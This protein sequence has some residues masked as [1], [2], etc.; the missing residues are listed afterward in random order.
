MAQKRVAKPYIVFG[1]GHPNVKYLGWASSIF[2][3]LSI[4]L[5]KQAVVSLF[6]TPTQ[7]PT[8]KSVLTFPLFIQ[9]LGLVYVMFYVV[10][11]F[12]YRYCFFQ[13]RGNVARDQVLAMAALCGAKFTH[14]G[15]SCSYTD[16]VPLRRVLEK[17]E[18]LGNT[19]FCA[20]INAMIKQQQQQDSTTTT[21][22]T[23]VFAVNNDFAHLMGR[24]MRQLLSHFG[25]LNTLDHVLVLH[26]E[27][28]LTS[29]AFEIKDRG[30]CM[31]HLGVKDLIQRVVIPR[32]IA[33]PEAFWPTVST[34]QRSL[35]SLLTHKSFY[36]LAVGIG[37]PQV[38]ADFT[39][40]YVLDAFTAPEEQ[41]MQ[42]VVMNDAKVA[43]VGPSNPQDPQNLLLL[44]TILRIAIKGEDAE[45][46]NADVQK[47]YQ[48]HVAQFPTQ[49]LPFPAAPTEKLHYFDLMEE[50]GY[51]PS[52]KP[53]PI[54]SPRPAGA[55]PGRGADHVHFTVA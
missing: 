47:L 4:M 30:T 44:S 48:K 54:S 53:T 29:G 32:K 16:A 14:T 35:L 24:P 18:Q 49:C 46:V 52:A 39:T 12:L 25:L 45:V 20:Q 50:Y 31:D 27:P 10:N 23:F 6:T 41:N 36:R 55:Q 3:A 1:L 40:Q 26:D 13:S 51:T 11:G 2:A 43:N 15:F 7:S 33:N 19:Q 38:P 8:Q 21:D 22:A 34:R 5:L 37:K 42:F 28:H 17:Q 9:L